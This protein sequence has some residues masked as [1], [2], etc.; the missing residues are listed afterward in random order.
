MDK[1][2]NWVLIIGEIS[3]EEN[4]MKKW[5][6]KSWLVALGLV[7]ILS[8]GLAGCGKK[9]NDN[10][11]QKIK[12][13]G[14][15]VIGTSA[16]YAPFEFPIV[17]NGH[18]QITGYDILIAK[19]IAKD[20]GVKLKVQNTEFSSLI[21]D[22]KGNKVDL[23]MAGM[24]STDAR[25]KQVA[26]S[27]SYYTV[28]NVLL[29][30]K[31]DANKYNT[32]ADTKGAQIGAQQT[33]TQES[34]AKN[35]TKANVVAEGM[36]TSLT[37]EL[38]KGKLDGVVVENE[39]ADNYLKNYPNQYAVANV[40]LTTPKS[41]RYINVAGRKGDK[42]LMKRVNK[43]ITKMQKNGQMDKLLQQSQDIQSKYGTAK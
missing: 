11:I 10:S 12:D 42:K 4:C 16:D 21:S 22:L 23:V 25:K 37:T 9:D 33:T 6:K 24:V 36:V 15:L 38:L 41:Q 13:K 35:Q 27:K 3:E 34:I 26:F 29:V 1:Y 32:I 20:L 31:S 18:K 19:Q 14:T 30:K 40:K 5:M 43:V 8:I 39:I 2:S 17:K 28:K 7:M